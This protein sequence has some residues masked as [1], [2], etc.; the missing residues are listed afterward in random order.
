M[1]DRD[2]WIEHLPWLGLSMGAIAFGFWCLLDDWR[3]FEK[4]AEAPTGRESGLP[5]HGLVGVL[6][7]VAGLLGL[8][9]TLLDIVTKTAP[10]SLPE[11]YPAEGE[12]SRV[13]QL[14]PPL[15]LPSQELEKFK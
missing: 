13:R 7:I 6:A 12:V 15:L 11:P 4:W 9:F 5:H 14:P 2:V 3:D 1:D 8:G 10:A